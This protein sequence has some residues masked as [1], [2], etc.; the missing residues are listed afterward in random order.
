MSIR[1]IESPWFG[2]FFKQVDGIMYTVICDQQ[3]PPKLASLYLDCIVSAFAD[4]L[5]T[6]YG[7]SS[8][9]RSKL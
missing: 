2:I 1:Q 5:K 6:V 8:N 7:G 4:E 3:Y 9:I